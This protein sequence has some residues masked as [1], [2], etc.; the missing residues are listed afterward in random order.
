[1]EA[2]GSKVRKALRE[3]EEMVRGKERKEGWWDEKCRVAKREVRRELRVWRR[4]GGGEKYRSKKKAYKELCE[5]K[6]TEENGRWEKVV[7]K[8]KR[9]GQVWEVVRRERKRRKQVSRDIEIAAA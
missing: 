1:M 9:E 2:V 8:A 7:G 5:S 6:K 3:V 4:E